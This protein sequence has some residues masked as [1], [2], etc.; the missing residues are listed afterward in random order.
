MAEMTHFLTVASVSA[1]LVAAFAWTADW[2]R[3]RRKN[4]DRVGFMPWTTIFF[5][6]LV[7][8]VVLVGLAARQ[9]LAG[10]F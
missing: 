7:A 10:S 3:R 4:L 5:C 8:A 9:W 1:T 6:A 2:R